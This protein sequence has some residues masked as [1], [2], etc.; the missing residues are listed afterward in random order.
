M[1]DSVHMEMLLVN[2]D[3]KL[4]IIPEFLTV[5]KIFEDDSFE[6]KQKTSKSSKLEA[7]KFSSY[8]VIADYNCLMLSYW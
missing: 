4:Y 6:V 7:L 8:M 3:T 2:C 1:D 5:T